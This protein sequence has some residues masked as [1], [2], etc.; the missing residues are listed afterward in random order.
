MTNPLKKTMAW[1][2]Q[3]LEAMPSDMRMV[4]VEAGEH[5]TPGPKSALVAHYDLFGFRTVPPGGFD[6]HNDDHVADLGCWDWE[7]APNCNFPGIDVEEVDWVRN[8]EQALSD[9]SLG[10]LSR[11][12]EI[13]LLFADHDGSVHVIRA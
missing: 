4:Y 9:H 11:R 13:L 1:L 7:A 10:D 3:S 8:L 6:P 5:M 2:H 12:K